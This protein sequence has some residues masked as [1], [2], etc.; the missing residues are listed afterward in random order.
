MRYHVAVLP[1]HR[2]GTVRLAG[3]IDGNVICKALEALY[4]HSAWRPGFSDLW[5]GLGIQALA[6]RPAGADRL[7]ARLIELTAHVGPGRTAIVTRRELDAAFVRMVCARTPRLPR[8]RQIFR[9]LPRAI[10]WVGQGVRPTPG[11][12]PA[13]QPVAQRSGLF[14]A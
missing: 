3:A 5:D 6:V 1:E 11:S 14:R 10:G 2:I 12:Q 9:S 13:S 8:A 4:T 7:V